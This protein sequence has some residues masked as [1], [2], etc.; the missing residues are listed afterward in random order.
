MTKFIHGDIDVVWHAARSSIEQKVFNPLL[1]F[2]H[3]C[4]PKPIN[5]IVYWTVDNIEN[6]EQHDQ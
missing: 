3:Q 2:V 6:A 1:T 5:S 4:L